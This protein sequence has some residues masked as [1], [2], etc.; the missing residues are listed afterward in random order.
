[1]D[2][3][4]LATVGKMV[5]DLDR[6]RFFGSLEIVFQAGRIAYLKKVET[7][8]LSENPRESRGTNEPSNPK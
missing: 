1:M 4:N 3:S 6:Q 2:N 5:A 7:I 8:K